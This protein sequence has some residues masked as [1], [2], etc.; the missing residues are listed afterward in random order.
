MNDFNF[1]KEMLVIYFLWPKQEENSL[2]NNN[3]LQLKLM[4][5][6]TVFAASFLV[7]FICNIFQLQR[8]YLDLKKGRLSDQKKNLYI[9]A[10]FIHSTQCISQS[11][12]DFLP[13]NEIR[14]M[15]FCFMIIL[16]IYLGML[17]ILILSLTLKN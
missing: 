2:A 13:C 6:Q 10:L 8:M 15:V 5:P 14:W 1:W 12:Q 7:C 3:R 11:C 9:T 17:F 4:K 16:Q